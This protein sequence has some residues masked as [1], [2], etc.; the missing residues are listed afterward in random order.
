MQ[1]GP[2]GTCT[3]RVPEHRDFESFITGSRHAYYLLQRE[4]QFLDVRA[5]SCTDVLEK[6]ET[7]GG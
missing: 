1:M 6:I 7:K 3:H 2:A 5:V 4:T